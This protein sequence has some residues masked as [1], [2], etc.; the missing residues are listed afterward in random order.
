MKAIRKFLLAGLVVWLPILVTYIVLHFIVE[1]LDNTIS[2]LPQ[3]Y[4]PQNLIGVNIPGLGVLLSL[5]M[6]LLTGIIATN[7]IGQRFVAW[8]EYV[9][10]KIP[11]VRSI[12]SSTK[13]VINAI[14]STNSQAFRRVLLVEY[15]RKGLWSIAFQTGTAH[16][17]SES[18][19]DKQLISI[20][21]P[22]T[23]NPTSGFLMMIPEQ[24]VIVLSMSIDDALKL[25][26]SLGVMSPNS[27]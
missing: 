19:G 4:Q 25:I 14:L 11:L 3:G 12:Y 7:F 26:I 21:V 9:L 13:Q 5:S 16:S 27:A 1:L 15:P 20:F 6:L 10:D 18:L 8:S 22:T 17:I 23:P 24:D 2:L